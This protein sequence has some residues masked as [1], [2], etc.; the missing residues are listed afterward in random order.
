MP[1]K[2][3]TKVPKSQKL[4]FDANLSLKL[5]DSSSTP[6]FRK[7]A[8][9]TFSFSF[10]ES[11][12]H[13]SQL[14]ACSVRSWVERRTIPRCYKCQFSNRKECTWEKTHYPFTQLLMAMRECCT[15][16][17]YK[18]YINFPLFFIFPFFI[19]TFLSYSSLSA[20]FLKFPP[21]LVEFSFPSRVCK[22]KKKA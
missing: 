20:Y 22:R 10:S 12:L 15:Y 17:L 4:L 7:R 11:L 8:K 21:T 5:L 14:F 13:I 9:A 2:P 3:F 1:R 16:E 19:T 6:W 18:L